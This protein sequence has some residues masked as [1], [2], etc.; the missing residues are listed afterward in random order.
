MFPPEKRLNKHVM[1]IIC[2]CR[3]DC[4]KYARV[5]RSFMQMTSQS[6]D[7]INPTM[8]SSAAE[9]A[10]PTPRMKQW[11]QKKTDKQFNR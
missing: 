4:V 9:D 5:R 6:H 11:R 3:V 8:R 1:K 2:I 10:T 7:A